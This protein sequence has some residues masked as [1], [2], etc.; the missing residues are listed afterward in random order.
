[1]AR[2]TRQ[3][4]EPVNMGHIRSH[5]VRRLLVYCGNGA[6]CDH[7]AQLDGDFLPDETQLTPLERRM[8]CTKR[9]LIGADV[10]PDWSQTGKAPGRRAQPDVA[11]GL[12]L[13]EREQVFR[14]FGEPGLMGN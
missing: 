12:I 14:E 9:G 11:R 6:W 1:M 7:S 13:R 3:T 10:W 5:G 2:R 8:V 4:F